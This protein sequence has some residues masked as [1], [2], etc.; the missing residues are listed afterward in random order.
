[1][2]GSVVWRKKKAVITEEILKQQARNFVTVK[3]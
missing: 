3:G 1:M 2:E